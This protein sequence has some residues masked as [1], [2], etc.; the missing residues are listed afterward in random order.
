MNTQFIVIFTGSRATIGADIAIR[1]SIGGVIALW[2]RGLGAI[3]ELLQDSLHG[4]NSRFAIGKLIFR[5]QQILSYDVRWSVHINDIIVGCQ[6]DW[7]G[8]A[9]ATI[10][11]FVCEI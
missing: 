10:V 8:V 5:V 7:A 9:A 3:G 6:V 11:R 2:L 4:W 1:A